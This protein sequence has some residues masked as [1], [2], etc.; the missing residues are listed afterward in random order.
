MNKECKLAF[1]YLH[2]KRAAACLLAAAVAFLFLITELYHAPRELAVYTSLMLS[3]GAALAFAA[4]LYGYRAVHN[5]LQVLLR[6]SG[7]AL[8]ELPA[9]RGLLDEDWQ[10]LVRAVDAARRSAVER[11]EAARRDAQEY[12]T[13]WAHQI[14]TPLAAMQLLAQEEEFPSQRMF[15]SELFQTQQYVDMVM[16]YQRMASMTKDLYAQKVDV[17]AAG[18]GGCTPRTAAVCRQTAGEA[19]GTAHRHTGPSLTQNG[20]A[21]CWSSF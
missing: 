4:G 16:S 21:L 11:S 6:Q 3:T 13:L 8:E 10:A 2:E 17:D 18:A 1:A 5:A 19:G 14:K 7:T 9:P 12:Y 20:W 15:L